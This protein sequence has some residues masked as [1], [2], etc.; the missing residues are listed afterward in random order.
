MPLFIYE[1]NAIVWLKEQD[2]HD[3]ENPDLADIPEAD[4]KAWKDMGFEAIWFL[5]VW[6]KGEATRKI[7]LESKDLVEEFE[8]MMPDQSKDEIIG[9]PFSIADYCIAP[10]LGKE[11]TLARLRRKLN[12]QGLK[13]ILDFVPNHMAVDHS[14][15]YSHPERFVNGS[16]IEM[17]RAPGNYFNVPDSDTILAHG[18]D[19]YFSGWTDTV[20]INIFSKDARKAMIDIMTQ[21]AD[22]CDGIRCD[23]AM[24]LNNDVFKR[25]WGD[26]SLIDYGEAP[27][28]FWEEAITAVHREHSDFIF[29]AE[30]YW[31]LE[32]KMREMGFDFMYDKSTYDDA[33]SGNGA[34]IRGHLHDTA[35]YEDHLIR[36]LENHDEDRAEDVFG[37][38]HRAMATMVSFLPGPRLFHDGQFEGR[39]VK[40]PVQFGVRPDER[41]DDDL[42]RFYMRLLELTRNPVVRSGN[43]RPL[44]VSAAWD[45]NDTSKLIVTGWRWKDDERYLMAV[46]LGTQQ[47]QAYTEVPLDGIDS[48]VIE[49]RDVLNDIVY[50]RATDH[51]REKGLYLDMPAG[52]FHVFHTCPAPEGKLPDD[53]R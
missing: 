50:Y 48:E 43:F 10:D 7:C 41:S 21:I 1:I 23:M 44:Y 51:V 22:V 29:L 46:N 33:R 13:L 28:E 16:E 45:G 27:P 38:R 53:R 4:I 20:Q 34:H 39:K 30:V 37:K 32:E 25:T 14:W 6:T 5:G 17:E 2:W 15:V 47:A 31:N 8:E 24:L 18:R 35:H 36:F 40:L 19:P 26:L 9:S 49:L 52:Q 42:Y 3:P 11:D 12:D